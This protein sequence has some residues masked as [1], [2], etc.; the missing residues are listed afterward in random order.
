L[1]KRAGAALEGF[2]YAAALQTTEE[3]F[4]EFC[5]DYV[6]LVKVRS[7]GEEDS[8][9]RRSAHATLGLALRTFLR[10]FAPVLPYVTEEVWS[11]RFEGEGRFRSIHTSPWPS[12]QET[13]E[14]GTSTEAG[15]FICAVEV[16]RKVRATKTQSKRSLRWPV[17]AIE[18][19]GPEANRRTLEQVLPDVLRAGVAEAEAVHLVDGPAPE[20]ER[21][22]VRVELAEAP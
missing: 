22:C 13:A 18:V 17:S 16:L 3:A 10:L 11:W 9:G 15:P 2:D 4:W 19:V 6:E 14:A 21:F 12:P 20:G 1:V 7:Y 8:P 5:D